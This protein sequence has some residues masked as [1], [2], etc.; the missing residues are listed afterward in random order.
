VIIFTTRSFLLCLKLLDIMLSFSLCWRQIVTSKGG[1]TTK[2]VLAQGPGLSERLRYAASFH[3]S[4][5]HRLRISQQLCDSSNL[6][7]ELQVRNSHY[8]RIKR[9]L[10]FIESS[11]S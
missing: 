5:G 10:K 4:G 1:K 6:L 11:C 7:V 3:F 8:A 9:S 2:G